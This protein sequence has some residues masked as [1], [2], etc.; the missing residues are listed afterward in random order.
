[1]WNGKM[2]A[3]TFSYDDGTDSDIRFLEIINKYGMKA[4]FNLNGGM[5]R[6]RRY[7]TKPWKV[8]EATVNRMALEDQREMY[9]GHEVAVHSYT[10]PHL[11]LLS[12]EMLSYEICA[13]IQKLTE[14]F[15]YRP[16]GMAYPFGTYSDAVV[17]F[18]REQGIKYA[19]TVGKSHSF[20]MPVDPLRWDAT[21]HH[22]EPE[23]MAL[24]KTFVEAKPDKP[25]LF[26]VW[27]HTC[28]FDANNNWDVLERFCEYIA[29]HDDIFYGTNA[30]CL[31][32]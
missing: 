11:E 18:I 17:D 16:V 31:L 29:G 32:K 10:H 20:D 9:V 25:M 3:L 7:C 24:A 8:K 4:T 13:D 27:G 14:E 19:R 15:G 28:E 30:E 1:M 5:L 6:E 12:P 23:L 21:C 26:S 22:N 2:K